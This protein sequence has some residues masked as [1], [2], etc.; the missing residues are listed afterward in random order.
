MRYVNATH[1][2]TEAVGQTASSQDE[3]LDAPFPLQKGAIV[4]V[5]N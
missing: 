1:D 5:I 3:R 4:G 2:Q